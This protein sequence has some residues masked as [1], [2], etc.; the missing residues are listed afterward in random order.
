MTEDRD[1]AAD[2]RWRQLNKCPRCGIDMQRE[3]AVGER[4]GL[5][6]RCAE[7]GRFRYSWD[8][9]RLEPVGDLE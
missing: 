6:Y 9:D 7:H 2:E 8:A 5:Y 3:T 4:I 1:A